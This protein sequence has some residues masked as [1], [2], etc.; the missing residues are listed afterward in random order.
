MNSL[1]L[2]AEI[3]RLKLLNAELAKALRLIRDA[4]P[5]TSPDEMRAIA[6]LSMKRAQA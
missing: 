5:G 3:E 4:A 6:R 1:P 2:P